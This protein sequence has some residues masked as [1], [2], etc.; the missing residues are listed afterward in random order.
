MSAKSSGST[1]TIT[2]EAPRAAII[3]AAAPPALMRRLRIPPPNDLVEPRGAPAGPRRL[4]RPVRSG[5]HCPA[6]PAAVQAYRRAS[7]SKG[8]DVR[9]V[10]SR[11]KETFQA[12]AP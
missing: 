5:A 4:Q 2:P 10:N 12:L 7:K 9:L 6:P 8:A 3:A 11:G 1:R